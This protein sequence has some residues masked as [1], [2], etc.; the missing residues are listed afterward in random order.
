MYKWGAVI[1]LAASRKKLGL[2]IDYDS[3]KKEM[4]ETVK[5]RKL[6]FVDLYFKY[7][8]FEDKEDIKKAYDDVHRILSSLDADAKARFLNTIWYKRT[9]EEWGKVNS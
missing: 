9:I 2:D 4:K 5:S 3:I 1:G 8:V 6:G 7:I